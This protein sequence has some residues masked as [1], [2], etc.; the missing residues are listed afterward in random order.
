MRATAQSSKKA[1]RSYPHRRHGRAKRAACPDP[2][3]KNCSMHSSSTRTRSCALQ[4]AARCRSPTIEA[5]ATFEWPKSG[6]K[7]PVPSE[8][9]RTH[10]LTAES[11]VT[12]SRCP[13]QGYNLLATIQIALNGNAVDMLATPNKI[14][15]NYDPQQP[16]CPFRVGK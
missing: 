12:C 10:M 8:T 6:R 16:D 13:G 9:S 15:P 14:I 11:P 1:E 3:R 5:S 4:S 7:F 2:R